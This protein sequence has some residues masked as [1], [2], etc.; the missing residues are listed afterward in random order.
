MIY[1]LSPTPWLCGSVTYPEGAY[2]LEPGAAASAILLNGGLQFGTVRNPRPWDPAQDW[3][4]KGV[5]I[6]SAGGY[7][8]LLFL[9]P[10]LRAMKKTWPGIQIDM[11]VNA[12]FTDILCRH[13]AITDLVPYPTPAPLLESYDACL[14]LE[15]IMEHDPRAAADH[16]VDL[17]AAHAGV[18]LTAGRNCDYTIDPAAAQ[19][20]RDRFPQRPPSLAPRHSPGVFQRVRP[21][22]AV[23]VEANEKCRSYPPRF[24]YAALLE[25]TKFADVLMLGAPLEGLPPP[26]ENIQDMRTETPHLT[27]AE[28]CALMSQ[29]DVVLAPDSSLCHIAG[30]MGLPTVALFGSFDAMLRTKYHLSVEVM[31][32]TAP[33]APCHWNARQSTWP[34]AGPCAKSHQCE[35]LAA[36]DPIK[37][38]E[39]V[40]SMLPRLSI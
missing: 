14:W 29:C 22:V 20:M 27:F 21:R 15:G 40:R 5:L 30:A 2:Y 31:Q 13:P 12:L 23:Q 34:A 38:A 39:K 28:S 16:I 17:H 33:C 19:R 11:A 25:I 24:L 18:K 32:G 10:L 9:T 37:V 8:D 4:G 6:A 36:L 35:A 1:L 3:N 26:P 7:G